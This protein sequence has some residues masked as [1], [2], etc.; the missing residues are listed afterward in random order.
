MTSAPS[1][2]RGVMRPE[3]H[4]S[5]EC[6]RPLPIQDV[7]S[8]RIAIAPR[9][10][11]NPPRPQDACR[12][13]ALRRIA[14]ARLRYCGLEALLGDV[15]V[16][17]SELL[18]NALLHSGTKE[19]DLNIVVR[20]RC[21]RITVTDGMPGGAVLKNADEDAESGRGLFLVEALVTQSGGTWGTSEDGAQT[22]C[23]L[24]VRREERP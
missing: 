10:G 3:D 13:G 22:W 9:A 16:I 5:G 8:E 20:D 18:T 4:P 1:V 19:I 6:W 2:T 7:M 14:A 15:M 21:L 12:V 24:P 11:G 17:V 23:S